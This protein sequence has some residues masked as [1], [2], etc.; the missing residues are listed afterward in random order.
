MII[1]LFIIIINIIIIIIIIISLLLWL[2]LR[3]IIIIIIIIYNQ[4]FLFSRYFIKLSNILQKQVCHF[5]KILSG[6]NWTSKH[7]FRAETHRRLATWRKW[8]ACDVREA[9]E[10]LENE[11]S[12]FSKLSVASLMS[13]F[14]L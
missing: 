9:K 2:L 13:Q 7:L 11:L 5:V 4:G 8:R 1:I 3:I 12:S 6:L 10:V 14:I